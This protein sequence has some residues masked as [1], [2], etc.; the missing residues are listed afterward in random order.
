MKVFNVYY[1]LSGIKQIEVEKEDPHEARRKFYRTSGG[2]NTDPD[3]LKLRVIEITESVFDDFIRCPVCNWT[4]R[5]YDYA[6][7]EVHYLTKIGALSNWFACSEKVDKNED[8]QVICQNSTC[9]YQVPF[10]PFHLGA[11]HRGEEIG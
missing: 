5:Y 6:D 4:C 10:T 9:N 3:N 8:Q 2:L 7:Q 1:S 11:L